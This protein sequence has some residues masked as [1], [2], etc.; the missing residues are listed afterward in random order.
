MKNVILIFAFFLLAAG[1]APTYRIAESNIPIPSYPVDNVLAGLNDEQLTE[2]REKSAD[3][4][5]RAFSQNNLE[6]RHISG[7]NFTFI[8]TGQLKGEMP[9]GDAVFDVS[10]WRLSRDFI[11]IEISLKGSK[12]KSWMVNILTNVDKPN[13]SKA[14]LAPNFYEDPVAAQKHFQLSLRFN[15]GGR[16]AGIKF[17]EACEILGAKI[18]DTI[19]E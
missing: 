2:I 4:I 5:S 18:V 15:G 6:F 13:G 8:G 1:C 16:D 17:S 19:P 10:Q 11:V 9:Y 7:S 3:V 14:T 12:I